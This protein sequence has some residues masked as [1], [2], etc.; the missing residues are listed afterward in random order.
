MRKEY[1]YLRNQLAATFTASAFAVIGPYACYA[2]VHTQAES[3]HQNYMLGR[4][5]C[6]CLIIVLHIGILKEGFSAYLSLAMLISRKIK[7][8]KEWYWLVAI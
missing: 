1:L 2:V 3:V 8:I 7:K 5:V 4:Y 6:L